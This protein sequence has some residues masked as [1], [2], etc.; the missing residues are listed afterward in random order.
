MAK[1]H[2][3]NKWQE[4]GYQV[5]KGETAAYRYYGNNIFT[6]DQVVNTDED[7]ESEYHNNCFNCRNDVHSS[8]EEQCE[9]CD[10]LICSHCNS[11]GCDYNNN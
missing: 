8:S 2:T 7:D 10:W 1:G 6:R 3:Y 11:C 5:K 4:L 9:E